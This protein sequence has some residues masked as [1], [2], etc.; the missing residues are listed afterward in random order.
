VEGAALSG[1]PAGS[2]GRL[3]GRGEVARE[4]GI[5]GGPHTEFAIDA[6]AYYMA[7]LRR[8]WRAERTTLERHQ[9]AQASYNA[10][11]GNILKAQRFCGHAR[12]WRTVRECLHLVTGARNAQETKTYVERIERWRREMELMP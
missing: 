8:I 11:A 6:G 2:G 1:I 9:L 10:G 4:L 5:S 3:K 12:L 7:K